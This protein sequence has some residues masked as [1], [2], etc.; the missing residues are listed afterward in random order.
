MAYVN[1]DCKSQDGM[2]NWQCSNLSYSQQPNPPAYNEPGG[3]RNH[4]LR[5]KC[6]Q[7]CTTSCRL[8]EVIDNPLLV[9]VIRTGAL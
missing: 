7:V 8:C 2:R 4:H 9:S 1:A 6:R 5:M 3:V